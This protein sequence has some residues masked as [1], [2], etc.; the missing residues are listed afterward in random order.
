MAGGVIEID[1]R[2]ASGRARRRALLR[3]SLRLLPLLLFGAL[4]LAG[5][6][7]KYDWRQKITVTVETPEGERSGSSV[8][9]INASRT[10]LPIGATAVSRKLIGEAVVVE[11]PRQRYLFALLSGGESGEM[12]GLLQN[13]TNNRHGALTAESL[14][15]AAAK[16]IGSVHTISGSST[17]LL[18]TFGNVNYP[19]SVRRVDPDKLTAI[20]GPGYKIKSI[21][22]EVTSEPVSTG[23]PAAVLPWL[24]SYFNPH[25]ALSG[26]RGGNKLADNLGPGEIAR[27][28][29]P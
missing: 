8:Q 5:C 28:A 13:F 9:Q 15:A 23:R 11:L 12:V 19:E 10:W 26:K 2:I 18:V 29:C 27:G 6:S 21:T 16:P 4:A 22:L 14:G 3:G 20:F 24:C 17:P 25:R 1:G 7:R